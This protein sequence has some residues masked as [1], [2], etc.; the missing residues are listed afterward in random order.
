M[1]RILLIE[2]DNDIRE[3]IKYNLE[4]RSHT[5]IDHDNANSALITLEDVAIDIILLDI[6]LPGLKGTQFLKI[7]RDKQT[8]KNIPVIII[9]AKNREEDIIAALDGGADD[10][11]PKPFSIE[12][13]VAKINSILRRAE[14]V[15]ITDKILEVNN[16]SIDD[17]K[18]KVFVDK[19][20]I[21]LTL[22]EYELL[23]LFLTNKN[24]IFTRNQLL[25][26][27]WSYDSEAMTRTVDS[28]IASLRKKLGV[29]SNIIVSIPKIGYGV[30]V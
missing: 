10:Y 11:L 6:M 29:A 15:N 9:S 24:K 18:H 5:V 22:K 19:V 8:T 13:L 14:S 27:I 26:S 7:V 25:N 12:M 20:E 21:K 2:D 23:K 28:H 1:T 16:I 4:K 17:N 30:E 3:L